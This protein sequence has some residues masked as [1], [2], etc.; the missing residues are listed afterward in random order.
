MLQTRFWKLAIPATFTLLWLSI[1]TAHAVN[2]SFTGLAATCPFQDTGL[3]S[4]PT[5]VAGDPTN[6]GDHRNWSPQGVPGPNDTATIGSHTVS[7][8]GTRSVGRLILNNGTLGNGTLNLVGPSGSGSSSWTGGT[9][10]C[11]LT[12]AAGAQFIISGNA[13]R[14]FVGGTINNSGTVTWTNIGAVFCSAAPVF[15]NRSGG[16]FNAQSNANW[17]FSGG[18]TQPVF[19]N[20]T[21]STFNK[22]GADTTSTFGQ[23]AFNNSGT[24]NALSGTLELNGGGTSAGT[25]TAASAARVNISGILTGT[26]NPAAGGVIGI[27][28]ASNG[29]GGGSTLL[30]GGL[31]CIG[32]GVSKIYSG[33]VTFN[34]IVTT[35][36]AGGPGTLQIENGIITGTVASNL[37]SAGSGFYDWTGGTIGADGSIINIGSGGQFRI[38]G[39]DSRALTDGTVNNSGT[40]TWINNGA[41]FCNSAPIFNNKS[42][43]VF[44]AQSNANWFFSGGTAQPVFNNQAGST[45]NKSGVDTTSTFGQVLFNNSGT[46]NGL[47]GTLEL[48]G[49]GTSPGI[50]TAANG[51]RVNVS[52]IITATFNPA[53]GGIIGIQQGSNGVGG[54]NTF[55][56]TGTEF[57]GAGVSKIYSGTVM[58]NGTITTGQSSGS[59]TLEIENGILEGTATSRLS[60]AGTGFYN[61]T[62]GTISGTVIITN[63]GQFRIS[64]SASRSFTD[65]T[66]NNSGTVT[67]VGNGAIF[68]NGAPVFNNKSGGVFNARNNSS[69]FFSGGTTAPAFNNLAG[70]ILNKSG[71]DTTTTFGQVIFSNAGAINVNHSTLSASD[72]ITQTT[73]VTSLDGGTLNNPF[74]LQGGTLRGNG[75]INGNVINSGGT[76]EPG[77]SPGTISLAGNYQ[78]G[79]KGA[80]N[81]E[82]NGSAAA[83]QDHLNVTGSVTLA[84]DLNVT[85]GFTPA[86]G[87]KLTVIN[88]TGTDAVNGTFSGLPQG[89]K[90]AANDAVLQISYTG[91]DGN[92]VVIT[93]IAQPTLSINNVTV[94]EGTGTNVNATFTATLSFATPETVT[95]NAITANGTALAP[96]DYTSGGSTLTFAPGQTTKTFNVLVAGDSLDED[97]E[98]FFVLLSAPANAAVLRGRGV[99]TINDNDLPP[100]IGIENLSIGEGNAGQR[101]A[102]FRLVLSQA[103]GKAVKVN[104]ATAAGT[105]NP[106]TA[107]NDFVAVAP[108]QITFNVGQ[109]VTLAR[110]LIKGDLLTEPDETFLVNLSA[111]INGTLADNQATGTILNDDSDPALSIDD[112]EIIEGPAQGAPAG[113]KQLTFTVTLSKASGETVS[114][115]FATANGTAQSASD[116]VAQ[117]GSLAFAPGSALTRTVSVLINGDALDE[118]DET[119]FVFLSSATNA[120]ISRARGIGT[121]INDDS[122][123]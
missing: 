2:Y 99:G 41:I 107:G 32:A 25:F 43:G 114:V 21:G 78:Q 39:S 18:T 122:S 26:L 30:G 50:F 4:P 76:V 70:A 96:G 93:R 118:N 80:L 1:G 102:V 69:W 72:G 24:V 9:I 92:D 58:V 59:G 16:I 31:D 44:N 19:N 117:N 86:I 82:F 53:A 35:G 37:L 65:G 45:F 64:G 22:S 116:Y 73:G 20:Q 101:T 75:A 51:G 108:T 90:L 49:G 79:A 15:N 29:L 61:W 94:T 62:G 112:V 48:N 109:T 120:N 8:F 111:P 103:S 33:I 11:T 10:A 54:G 34:G 84:G 27:Q 68:C 85:L 91:G 95:V 110:V 71:A 57:I 42:G 113:T 104:Y 74:T 81:V 60:S 56:N 5:F 14:S 105:T 97:P 55:L 88:N 12:V 98:N 119:L 23:V 63:T 40:F 115:N 89:A 106:A 13:S 67:W 28:Q 6:W 7:I 121:I 66:I 17:F 46:V 36:Q 100:T 87:A 83:T 47:S 38:R 77:L 123:G 3:C 52:G